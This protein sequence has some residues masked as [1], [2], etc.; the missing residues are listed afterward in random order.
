MAKLHEVIAV[1]ASLLTTAKKINEETIRTFGKRDEHF[2]ATVRQTEYFAEE[3]AKQNTVEHKVM[4]TTVLDR[5]L[6]GTSANV[7]AFDVYLKKEATNQKATADLV[8]GDVVLA[9]NVP[10]TVLLGLETKVAELRAVYEAIP[11]LAPGPT[12]EADADRRKS[13]GV[14]RSVHPDV[15]FR[16]RKTVRPIVMSPATQHHP[17]QVQA[18]NED[19]TVAKITTQHWSGMMTSAQKS[20][21]LARIDRL[22][23]G[24]KR[25]R[26]R[27]NN[28]AVEER[29]IGA[30]IFN[31]I[32]EGIVT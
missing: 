29:T 8:V 17:A 27:A 3:D 32:H 28:Q 24:L 25:A 23:R 16:T 20:D 22:L 11:T 13:G 26:Q 30:E 1:E 14:Y 21:L 18:I 6:Y 4:L 2:V 12:W 15:T 19:V 9:A 10:V 31:Y 7:R 5:L